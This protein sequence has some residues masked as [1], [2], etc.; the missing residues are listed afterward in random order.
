MKLSVIIVSW[1]VREELTGCLE[2]LME[3]QP[4]D[5]F[6]LIVVDNASTDGTAE[7]IRESF[8]NCRIIA[9][10]NNCGF[11]TAN[12]QGIK[13][14]QGEYVLLLNPDTIIPQESLNILIKFMDENKDVGICGPRLLN[15]DNS[16]Q[17]SARR[18]PTFRAALHRHTIFRSIGLFR[19][20]YKRWLMKDFNHN[21]QTDVD[22][23]MGA[24]LLIRRSVLDEV[25]M[26][27]EVFF[28]YYE[29]VDLCFRIK[30]KGYR[31][32]FVPEA[33]IIHLGGRSASQV[34]VS[35][36]IAAMTSLLK[37]FQK[38][39]GGFSTGLFACLFKS[40]LVLKDIKTIAVSSI[41][42]VFSVVVSDKKHREK[43]SK[44][45]K[46]SLQLLSNYSWRSLFKV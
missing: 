22:Q 26:L 12:N 35:K 4:K 19:K 39:Y 33:S 9:N 10:S 46:N 3:S 2:S 5:D 29:E 16:T 45:I 17:P 11:A 7:A 15:E 28:M 21:E 36:R 30:R 31:V 44:K 13:E 14:S 34:P 27:D 1:N 23:L 25:G 38:H 8:A 42:Y 41:V 18:F 20:Q 37:F 24:C 6:E 32:V 40:A 43:C